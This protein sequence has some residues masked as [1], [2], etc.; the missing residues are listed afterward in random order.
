MNVAVQV[1]G[2]PELKILNI[3]LFYHLDV[4]FIFPVMQ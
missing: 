4:G 1:Q 2:K 3:L